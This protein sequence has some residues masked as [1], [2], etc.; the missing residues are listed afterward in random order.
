MGVMIIQRSQTQGSNSDEQTYNVNQI[1]NKTL[2]AIIFG[3]LASISWA[4]GIVFTESALT[5]I[6]LLPNQEGFSTLIANAIRFPFAAIILIFMA[7]NSRN[8][9]LDHEQSWSTYTW[10][11]LFLGAIIG[12]SIGAFLYAEAT[13]LAGAAFVSIIWTASPLFAL[14]I[15]W[16]LNKEKINLKG[17]IGVLVTTT[18]VILILL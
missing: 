13:R 14:P 11:W 17:F 6:A 5:E 1:S 9:S 18:G 2:F 12:T 10:K 16:L 8:Q 15:T 7:L 3:F 4:L